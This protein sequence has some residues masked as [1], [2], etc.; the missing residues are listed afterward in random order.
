M[1]TLA[2]KAIAGDAQAEKQLFEKLLVRFQYLAKLKV[3]EDNCYDL[4]QEA[5]I[6]V[7]EKY[8]QQTFTVSFTAWANGVLKMKIGNYL[9]RKD[10]QK[11]REAVINE[12]I[13]PD[14]RVSTDP[15]LKRFVLDCLKALVKLGGNYARILNL[16]YHGF[17][18]AEICTK[19][20]IKPNHYYVTLS[21]GRSQLKT[22]LE[23]KG[24]VL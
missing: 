19:I 18:T 3:G 12:E 14:P 23:A 8:K 1:E 11:T 20:G 6:T 22:C 16:S 13:S 5:C 21:R 17:E 4:A 10:R 9:Q 2:T 7:F 15:N 24:V